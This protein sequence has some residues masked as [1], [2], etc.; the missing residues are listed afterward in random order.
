MAYLISDLRDD[1]EGISHGTTTN[2]IQNFYNLIYRAARKVL[3]HSDPPDT[4][5]VSS[6]T[7]LYDNITLYT[8]PTDLKGNKILDIRP[9]AGEARVAGDNLTQTYT[10]PFET[11]ADDNRIAIEMRSGT[12]F[13]RLRKAL[14][15]RIVLNDFESAT[16]NGT[17]TAAG[18]GSNL[19]TDETVYVTGGASLSFDVTSGTATLT[20]STMTQQDLTDH[21]N[22]AALFL[23]IY[24]PT[25]ANV[26]SVQLDWGSDSSNYYSKTVTT[27]QSGTSFQNG[28]NL[29]RFDWP[30]TDTGSPAI[31]SI[32]YVKLSIVATGGDISYRVDSLTSN[33]PFPWELVYYSKFLFRSSAGAFKEVPTAESDIINLDTDGYNLLLNVCAKF[34][35]Q[36]VQGKD[37]AMDV[38][39]FD[40]ELKEDFKAYNSLYPSEYMKPQ[41]FYYKL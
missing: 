7:N 35:S 25:A 31:A 30:S 10:K 40:K 9:Q 4:K 24:L 20:N 26:T 38:N 5:R 3:L 18:T 6:L 14:T 13:L 16:A 41:D 33:L 37:M 23:W 29:L 1:L 2:D 17:W 34:A 28:W 22:K 15:G 12:K 19:Q 11:W 32:D 21:L 27:T 39:F 8:A 36:Q